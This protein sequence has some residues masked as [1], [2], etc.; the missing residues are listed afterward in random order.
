MV[1]GSL[2][3]AHADVCFSCSRTSGAT[4]RRRLQP[5]YPRGGVSPSA[6]AIEALGGDRIQGNHLPMAGAQPKPTGSLC[7]QPQRYSTAR[8]LVVDLPCN[9]ILVLGAN[10]RATA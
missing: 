2:S 9:R 3:A 6:A 4:L 1:H 5:R 10:L 8:G 7:L